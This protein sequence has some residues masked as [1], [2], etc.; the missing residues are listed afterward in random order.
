MH[1]GFAL[2]LRSLGEDSWVGKLPRKTSLGLGEALCT[3]RLK[4]HSSLVIF[5][6]NT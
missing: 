5:V 4:G 1:Q 6:L 3:E 2:C